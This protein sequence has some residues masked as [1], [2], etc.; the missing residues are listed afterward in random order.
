MA[1]GS[2]GWRHE[3]RIR[4]RRWIVR[5]IF[6]LVLGAG[7]V[8]TYAAGQETAKI[9]VGNLRA[10]IDRLKETLATLKTHDGDLAASFESARVEAERWKQRFESEVPSGAAQD[11]LA[12]IRRQLDAGVKAERLAL[13]IQA[14][15]RASKCAAA[16]VSKRFIVRTPLTASGVG[17]SVTFADNA[18]TVTANGVSAQSPEGKAEARFDPAKPITLSFVHLGGG[19][20]EVQGI[21]PLSHTVALK[22]EEIRIGAIAG[23]AAGFLRVTAE[24]CELPAEASR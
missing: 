7:V 22:G 10:E 18:I 12:R 2:G 17:D 24:R 3:R 23:E 21:L 9:E 13:L 8:F 5:L 14:A 15:D 20:E 11:L 16:P 6:A 1:L 19:K 4:R